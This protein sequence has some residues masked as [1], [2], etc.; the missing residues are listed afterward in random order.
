MIIKEGNI[1]IIPYCQESLSN[2]GFFAWTDA[3]GGGE[4]YYKKYNNLASDVSFNANGDD[5][6]DFSKM[7]NADTIVASLEAGKELLGL[8]KK[9]ELS[10]VEGACGKQ[11]GF[12][13]G[14][15]KK[16]DW[17]KCAA[18][19]VRA[20]IEASRPKPGKGLSTGAWIGIGLGSIALVGGI[21]FLATRKRAQQ[22]PIVV[23]QAP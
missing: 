7:I 9:R 13:A 23:M 10:E 12:L 19:Y 15:K 8:F 18:D 5:E 1:K 3:N 16:Q 2:C 14:R 6:V 22:Q 4:K 11:P 21:I 17:A 20:K